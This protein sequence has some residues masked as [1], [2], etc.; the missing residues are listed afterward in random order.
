LLPLP[1]V[2]LALAERQEHSGSTSPPDYHV[3]MVIAGSSGINIDGSSNAQFD[4]Y[5]LLR[6]V[7]DVFGLPAVG[8]AASASSM[9]AVFGL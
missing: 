4:H 5:S 1:G 8:S 2:R 3:A 9:K 6:T 7:E